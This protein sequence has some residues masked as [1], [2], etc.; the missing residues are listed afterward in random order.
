MHNRKRLAHGS[1]A[2][3]RIEKGR[4]AM[5]KLKRQ[6]PLTDTVC[7]NGVRFPKDWRVRQNELL[8]ETP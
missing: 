7:I 6:K 8:S 1:D 3:Q 5:G 4:G 2:T